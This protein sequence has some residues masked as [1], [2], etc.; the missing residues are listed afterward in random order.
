VRVMVRVRVL[1]KV[2]RDIVW[3]DGLRA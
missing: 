2:N 1:G 3:S